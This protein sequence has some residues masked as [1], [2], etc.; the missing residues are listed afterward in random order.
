MT[1]EQ[2]KDVFTVVPQRHQAQP[3]TVHVRSDVHET[4]NGSSSTEEEQNTSAEASEETEEPSG[5]RSTSG[6]DTNS[7]GAD[8]KA[9]G[10]HEDA[11]G[12]EV[13]DDSIDPPN[14]IRSKISSSEMGIV[15]SSA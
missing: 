12:S 5:Q 1:G 7:L 10:P 11:S 4:A 8:P 14:D 9:S 15:S 2:E 13:E 3:Q 6:E